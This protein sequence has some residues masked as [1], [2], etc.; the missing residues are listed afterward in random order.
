MNEDTF[1]TGTTYSRV[2]VK[3]QLQRDRHSGMFTSTSCN[4]KEDGRPETGTLN[5]C[6]NER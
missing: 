2:E 1:S 6:L 3:I 5:F 4:T